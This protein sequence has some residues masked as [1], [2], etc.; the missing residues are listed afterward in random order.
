MRECFSRGADKITINS[1]AVRNPDIITKGM[2]AFGRQA[3]VVS[4]D[5]RRTP[6]NRHEVLIDGGH[7]ETGLYAE[8]WAAKVEEL[9]AGE[10]LLQSIDCDGKGTGYDEDLIHKVSSSTTIPVIACS[11][12]GRPDQFASG[13][14]AGASAVAAANLWHF[15]DL[16]DRLGKRSLAKSGFNVRL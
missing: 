8:E 12:V 14:R 13:I 5:S 15:K 11:G 6:C 2:K 4:I 3:I 10:I 9:G 7:T 16:M 1:E